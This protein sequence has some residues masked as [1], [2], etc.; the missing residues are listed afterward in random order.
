MSIH[1]LRQQ[2]ERCARLA[3]ACTDTAT[4]EELR[5]LAAEYRA[6]ASTPEAQPS[7]PM[8]ELYRSPSGDA[9]YLAEEENGRR[10]VR[11]QANAESGGHVSDMDVDAFLRMPGSPPEKQALQAREALRSSAEP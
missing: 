7:I 5:R 1:Y 10:F 8:Q 6:K 4:A 3:E 11:H 9:W 2:A